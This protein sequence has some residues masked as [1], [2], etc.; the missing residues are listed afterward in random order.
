MADPDPDIAL[1]AIRLIQIG[2]FVPHRDGAGK[3]LVFNNGVYG[4]ITE[5]SSPSSSYSSSSS[6]HL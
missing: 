5:V 4:M 1:E 3:N 2:V 6:S